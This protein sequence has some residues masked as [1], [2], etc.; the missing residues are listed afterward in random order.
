MVVI[1]T[2]VDAAVAPTSVAFAKM[3][4][5]SFDYRRIESMLIQALQPQAILDYGSREAVNSEF[6]KDMTR[7]DAVYHIDVRSIDTEELGSSIA[8]LDFIVAKAEEATDNDLNES[9]VET[10]STFSDVTEK[11]LLHNNMYPSVYASLVLKI[12]TITIILNEGSVDL[13]RAAADELAEFVELTSPRKT[14]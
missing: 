8:S 10:L 6:T 3:L 11:E 9:L 2:T 14:D 12:P 1:I 13:Y 4:R 7:D 5:T